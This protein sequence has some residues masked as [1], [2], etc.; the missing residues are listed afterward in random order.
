MVR[1]VAS[2]EKNIPLSK[3]IFKELINL[4]KKVWKGQGKPFL[5]RFP[6]I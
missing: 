2:S 3:I 6:L 5:K 1:R 4:F